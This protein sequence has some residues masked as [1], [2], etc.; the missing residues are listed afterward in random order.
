MLSLLLHHL[1]LLE[2]STQIWFSPTENCVSLLGNQKHSSLYQRGLIPLN[3][4]TN[5]KE[6]LENSVTPCFY[7]RSSCL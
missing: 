6:Y 5:T 3:M 7:Q 2:F 1:Y 4:V